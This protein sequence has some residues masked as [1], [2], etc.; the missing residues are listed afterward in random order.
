[1]YN[2]GFQCVTHKLTVTLH[3]IAFLHDF[4]QVCVNLL[5]LCILC[6]SFFFLIYSP[7]ELLSLPGKKIMKFIGLMCV[8]FSNWPFYVQMLCYYV[9]VMVHY[10]KLFPALSKF[11]NF[12]L[13]G[14][15]V[16]LSQWHC[17][18]QILKWKRNHILQ[19]VNS[20]LMLCAFTKIFFSKYWH[21]PVYFC[22]VSKACPIS[23]Y[24]IFIKV[25]EQV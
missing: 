7:F 11:N 17:F 5:L 8:C 6:L 13:F 3:R 24:D 9:N 15:M 21:V 4:S 16:L 18:W 22:C 23:I 12:R 25:K 10:Q 2:T 20:W 19:M 1:M 14:L